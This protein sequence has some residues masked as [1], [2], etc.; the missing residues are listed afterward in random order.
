MKD[1]APKGWRYEIR[2]LEDRQ[3]ALKIAR[4]LSGHADAIDA[5]MAIY[6]DVSPRDKGWPDLIKELASHKNLHILVTI[7]EE[8][9][10]KEYIAKTDFHFETLELTFDEKEASQI[11]EKLAVIKQPGQFLSFN[12]AWSRF[13]SKGP[14]MEFVYLVTHNESL[15]ERLRC[16]ID[17][18]RDMVR[19]GKIGEKELSLLKMVA[20]ASAYDARL[21]AKPLCEY[22]GLIEPA[23]TIELFE[24]EYLLRQREAGKH[25]EGLHP[26]RSSIL[27]EL[28]TDAEFTP[29]AQIAIDCLPIMVE[30][31][32][33]AFLLYSFSR[34][35][36]DAEKLFDSL[37]TLQP[38]TWTG[39]AGIFRALLWL[40]LSRYVDGN[41]EL[42][43]LMKTQMGSAWYFFLDFDVADVSGGTAKNLLK[44]L[45][46]IPEDNKRFFEECQNVQLPKKNVFAYASNWI[47]K[48]DRSLGPPVVLS[49]WGGL[50][51]LCFWVGH[52]NIQTS[53]ISS[54]DE[55]LVDG[56]IEILPLNY[57]A[58]L[59]SA[60]SILWG[61]KF[62]TWIERKKG[63]VISRFQDET[64]TVLIEDDTETIRIHFVIAIGGNDQATGE[65][66]STPS[67]H[68]TFHD[69]AIK[70]VELLRRLYPVRKNYGCQGYGHNTALLNLPHDDTLKTGIP[71]SHFLPLWGIKLNSRF[72]NL[73]NYMCRPETWREYADS[74]YQ[75]RNS[76]LV[77]LKE[78]QNGLIAHHRK[79]KPVD[80][81]NNYID[82]GRW[83]ACRS[84]GNH[85]PAFPKSVV[86]EWGDVDENSNKRDSVFRVRPLPTTEDGVKLNSEPQVIFINLWRYRNYLSSLKAYTGSLSNFFQQSKDV[87]TLNAFLGKAKS[88]Q[89]KDHIK[90][91]AS[92]NGIKTDGERLATYNFAEALKELPTLQREF[93]N[94]FSPFFD[95]NVLGSFEKRESETIAKAWSLWYQFAL[96][97]THHFQ[98]ADS[99]AFLKLH[100]A[101]K[102]VHK[103]IKKRLSKLNDTDTTISI[104]SE[105]AICEGHPA[106]WITF[107]IGRPVCLYESLE[108]IKNVL[109]T[110]LSAIEFNS[111][112]YFA[113]QFWSPNIVVIPLIRGRSINRTAWKFS[114]MMLAMGTY[115]ED[116]WWH[117]VPYPV[118]SESWDMLGLSSWEHPRLDIIN[119]FQS[120]IA[121]FSVLIAHADVFN[122]LPDLD[123]KGTDILQAYVSSI[124]QKMSDA[125]Q[126]YLDSASEILDYFNSIEEGERAKRPYLVQAVTALTDLHSEIINGKEF[127]GKLRIGVSELKEWVP[128]LQSAMVQAEMV[129]LLWVADFLETSD[130]VYDV[131]L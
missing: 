38:K 92:N 51:E 121:A 50:S 34:R 60:L 20:V 14:L 122:S 94:L 64:N 6:V 76:I 103:E 115:N 21:A 88:D 82:L 78:L 32:L 47:S 112:K 63:I 41:K 52:L 49:D 15:H 93:R 30:E 85:L 39:S 57:L 131:A 80:L 12:E 114:S 97:P 111:L 96:H 72:I 130:H 24:K 68:N 42:I 95:G 89:E 5:P 102:Q 28:L 40:G 9:L 27:V 70:R 113:L 81:F 4:A 55:Q 109:K 90:Q 1:F 66:E 59:H 106:L 91:I 79:Q 19:E 84:I 123:D 44:N 74:I 83:D 71:V 124:S 69:E 67:G 17:R 110:I 61:N 22:L 23:R 58:D 8:D 77:S 127:N 107:D 13:G 75:T 10:R 117:Y 116:K 119:K 35:P 48:I 2:L 118:P 36:D 3:H 45:D 128:H 100:T 87:I 105:N 37:L 26:I 56:A 62:E 65:Q 98:D 29:W 104:L 129:R 101:F 73:S 46:F 16:Q 43:Q 33:E 54:I 108:S 120:S 25:V 11:Y 18:L 125:L 99:E 53:I 31:D 7:R 126:G 86:D